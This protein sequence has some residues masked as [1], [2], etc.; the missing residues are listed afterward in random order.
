MTDRRS[1][2]EDSQE[3]SRSR[4]FVEPAFDVGPP[5]VG[6]VTGIDSGDFFPAPAPIEPPPQ[7]TDEAAG[8]E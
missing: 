8:S 6:P 5:G 4:G 1:K 2:P 3:P 7:S